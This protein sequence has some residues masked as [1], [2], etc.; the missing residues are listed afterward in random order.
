M[1]PCVK[2]SSAVKLTLYFTQ[3]RTSPVLTRVNNCS[4]TSDE[5]YRKGKDM[6]KNLQLQW[7]LPHIKLFATPHVHECAT[8]F[9]CYVVQATVHTGDRVTRYW[10]GCYDESRWC[11]CQTISTNLPLLLYNSI[12]AT[13]PLDCFKALFCCVGELYVVMYHTNVIGII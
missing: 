3:S 5:I 8:I 11:N 2:F 7:T 6:I 13:L 9:S 4:V 1:F 10:Q 12:M